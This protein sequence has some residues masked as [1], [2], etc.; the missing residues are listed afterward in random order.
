[1]ITPLYQGTYSVGMDGKFIPISP[2]D[3][4][5]RGHLKLALNPFLIRDDS[6]T[7]LIDAG[8]GSFGPGN[9]YEMMVDSLGRQGVEP[10]DIQHVYCSHLHTDHIG[11]LLHERFGTYELTFPNAAIW[12]SGREWK[13]FTERAE[14]K[15]HDDTVRWALYLET[16]GDLRFVEDTAPEPDS[17]TMTTIGGHTEFHQAILFEGRDE[18]AMMLG[19]VLG[20]PVAVNRKFAAKYDFDGKQSQQIR[21]HY[22]QKALEEEYLIL[23]YHSYN[24]AVIALKDFDQTKGYHIEHIPSD[25]TG[26]RRR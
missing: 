6:L 20:R 9:Q 1:M 14:Q 11:G 26:N 15:G 3:K 2:D 24:G 21:D 12:L 17:I 8:I 4:P 13:R 22:L 5:K 19:D 16:Y 23:T 10:E 7:A 18:K 25:S